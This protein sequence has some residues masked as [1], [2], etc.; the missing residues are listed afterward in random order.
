[1]ETIVEYARG[2]MNFI[3]YMPVIANAFSKGLHG[4]RQRTD[5]IASGRLLDQ[6]VVSFED[7][8][9]AGH[10]DNRLESSP[11]LGIW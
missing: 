11:L 9:I 1:M 8:T 5:V 7:V 10:S 2:L 4:L 6:K 3:F